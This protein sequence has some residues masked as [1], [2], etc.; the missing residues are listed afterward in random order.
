MYLFMCVLC[1]W[2]VCMHGDWERVAVIEHM[3]NGNVLW[4]TVCICLSVVQ[5]GWRGTV[6][7]CSMRGVI[8]N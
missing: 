3:Q 1:L 7:K 4:R 2:M 5:C 6:C 8:L